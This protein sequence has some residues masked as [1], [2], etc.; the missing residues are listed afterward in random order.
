M[1]DAADPALHAATLLPALLRQRAR[2][3]PQQI[4]YTF[5]RENGGEQ[6]IGYAELAARVDALAAQLLRQ[7]SP[8]GRALLFYPA[9]ID[10][11]V[12]F[13]ACL[14]AGVVAVPSA[15][16]HRARD[17]ARLAALLADAA[18][19]LV[20]CAAEM[21]GATTAALARASCAVRC[22]IPPMAAMLRSCRPRPSATSPFFNIRRVRPA[23]RRASKSRTPT[24]WPTCMRS[25][26]RSGFM[27]RR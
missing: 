12:A 3:T 15:P 21:R 9:G 20:L 17:A 26:A 16:A 19:D 27:P 5:L 1:A 10:F 14:A 4:A 24:C 23:S 8:G 25:A 2:Q 22:S 13:F 18:P 6:H 7:A 11:I